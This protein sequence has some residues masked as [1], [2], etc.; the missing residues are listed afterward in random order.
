MALVMVA[1]VLDKGIL[2][3]NFDS[4]IRILINHADP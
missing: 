1:Q 2:T 3:R 4:V